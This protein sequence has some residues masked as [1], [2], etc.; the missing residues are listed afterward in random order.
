MR[1]HEEESLSAHGRVVE[2]R[3]AQ[4][5]RLYRPLHNTS[6]VYT[7]RLLFTNFTQASLLEVSRPAIILL[8]DFSGARYKTPL[9]KKSSTS[10]DW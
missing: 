6:A 5:H 1:T 8:S 7:D 9:S 3:G 2:E 10:R 4:M